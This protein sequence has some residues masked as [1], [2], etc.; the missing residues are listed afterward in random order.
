MQKPKLLYILSHVTNSKG[1][2][3]VFAEL[4]SAG[5]E[6]HILLLNPSIEKSALSSFAENLIG[7]N[8]VCWQ[9]KSKKDLP[10]LVLKTYRYIKKNKINIVHS[11][12]FE[13][14]MIG[15]VAAKLAGV[16]KRIYTR[17]HSDYHHTYFPQAVKYDKIIN[18]L[19]TNIVAISKGVEQILIEKEN[20]NPRKIKVIPHGFDLNKFD[21]VSVERIQQI[22]KKYNIASNQKV[23]GVVSRFEIWKGV[24]YMID[25][26]QKY[27]ENDQNAILV[28]ANAMG[29]YKAKIEEYLLKIPKENYRMI[30]FEEDNVALFKSFNRFLHVPIDAYCEAYGQVYVEALMCGI[31][32]IFTHSG[33]ANDFVVHKHNAWV[34]PY[35]DSDAIYNAL[36]EIDQNPEIVSKCVIQGKLDVQ[37]SFS[38][39]NMVQQLTLL[40]LQ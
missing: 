29:P 28:L 10:L 6:L 12:L 4:N 23:I 14:S 7:K 16:K 24:Q 3:S 15:S 40:Y 19:S 2:E 21:N 13:G 18:L 11:H 20:A 34:V 33:I 32:S 37:S 1:F 26:F 31:P 39:N 8:L 35:K 27:L 17:H 5:F 36:M 9:L 30:E 22:K 25:A 38:I